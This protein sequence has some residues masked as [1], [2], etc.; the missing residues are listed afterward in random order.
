MDL[1]ISGF[2]F[3]IVSI[4]VLYVLVNTIYELRF[5]RL[6]EWSKRVH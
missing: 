6:K 2:P 4:P 3:F 5:G 1:A